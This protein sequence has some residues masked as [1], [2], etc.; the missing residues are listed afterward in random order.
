MALLGVYVF[1][2]AVCL[3]SGILPPS[4]FLA[5]TGL[6]CPT[7]GC[8]RSMVRLLHGDLAASLRANAFTVPIC[9]LLAASLGWLAR[10]ALTRRVLRLPAFLGWA[11]LIVLVAAWILKLL[12]SPA[13]W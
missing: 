1:W 9:I 7:T 2:N 8:A 13:Y 12:G 11:W 10:A 3:A 4:L 5:A 6:P